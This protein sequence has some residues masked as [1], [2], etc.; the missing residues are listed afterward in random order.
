MN[1]EIKKEIREAVKEELSKKNPDLKIYVEDI[2][3]ET[4]GDDLV[5]TKE[6][7]IKNI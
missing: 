1:K 4:Y 3:K 6:Y 7:L 2:L 5:S